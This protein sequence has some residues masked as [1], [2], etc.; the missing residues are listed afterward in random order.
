[1]TEASANRRRVLVIEPNDDARAAISARL[2]ELGLEVLEA[3]DADDALDF[4][5]GEKDI[6]H[7][8]CDDHVM[9]LLIPLLTLGTISD[10]PS[11]GT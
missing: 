5:R 10:E 11:S 4:L 2:E 1:M 8:Y 3:R 6:H 9:P 7:V